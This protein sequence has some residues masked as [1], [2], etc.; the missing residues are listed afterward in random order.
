MSDRE[1]L[2]HLVS[3]MRAVLLMVRV[4]RR[5]GLDAVRI[6]RGV[7]GLIVNALRMYGDEQQ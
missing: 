3:V 1:K 4:A 7:E 5:S 6:M 2:N